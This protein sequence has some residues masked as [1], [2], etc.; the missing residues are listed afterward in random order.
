[1]VQKG[2]LGWEQGVPGEV[3]QGV[4][5]EGLVRWASGL[6]VGGSTGNSWSDLPDPPAHTRGSSSRDKDR[7]VTVSSSVP[8]PAGG[9][10]SRTNC[11]QSTPQKVPNR[12]INEKSPYL[13]QHAYN[14]V[15]W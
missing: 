11:P 12:L 3:P 2:G 14:P 15:D 7:S 5:G 6:G 4:G 8:M 1:M 13:L 10:G 9:K